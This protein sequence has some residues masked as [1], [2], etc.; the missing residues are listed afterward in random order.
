MVVN[1]ASLPSTVTVRCAGVPVRAGADGTFAWGGA[2][3]GT[4]AG[5]GAASC[6]AAGKAQVA[7]SPISAIRRR[8]FF[9]P[10]AAVLIWTNRCVC[11]RL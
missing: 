11:F 2:C 9:M 8:R 6:P 7:N 1:I 3:L 5:A 10:P 4:C